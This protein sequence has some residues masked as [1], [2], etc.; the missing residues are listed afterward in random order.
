M[1]QWLPLF[2][3]IEAGELPKK[4]KITFRTPRKLKK[5]K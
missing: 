3:E 4:E 2:A 5:K 1:K